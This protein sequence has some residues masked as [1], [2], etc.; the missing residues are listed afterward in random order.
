MK[1]VNLS[2]A[3]GLVSVVTGTN[4]ATVKVKE[5]TGPA[6]QLSSESV[7]PLIESKS[8]T[9]LAQGGNG[10]AGGK[11]PAGGNGGSSQPKK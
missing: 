10:G 8:G 7:K 9:L 6:V 11:S 2:I 1:K 4:A 3:L 5:P